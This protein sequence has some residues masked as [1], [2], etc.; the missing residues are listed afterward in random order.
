MLKSIFVIYLLI[1]FITGLYLYSSNRLFEAFDLSTRDSTLSSSSCPDIL[2]NTGDILLLYNSKMEL[3]SGINPL[4][5][6]NLDEYINY[7]KSQKEKGI[8]CPILYI[9]KENDTQG[10]DV[11]NIR[12][13]P[14]NPQNNNIIIGEG[15]LPKKQ[16]LTNFNPVLTSTMS[17][18]SNPIKISDSSRDDL[19]YNQ[20]MYAGYDPLGSYIGEYTN[21]DAIHDSTS[22]VNSFSENP[23]DD[24][25]GG[26]LYTQNAIDSGKYAEDNVSIYIP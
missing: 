15:T 22:L 4:P 1:V 25:W 3:Q 11:Y 14:F 13:S 21:I 16:I 6:Y 2:V 19:P 12:D 7:V 9:Q 8:N 24:N 10:N 26:V 5:L 23:M 17:S 20:N 18:P